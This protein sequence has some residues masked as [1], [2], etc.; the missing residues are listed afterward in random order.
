MKILVV[1]DDEDIAGLVAFNLERQGWKTHLVH[2]GTEAWE[3][4][5]TQLPDMVILDIMLPGMDGLSIFREMKGHAETS[6]IPTL[7]LTARAQLED[8]LEGLQLGADDFISKPF[9][10][11]ELVLRVKNVANRVNTGA[12]QLVIRSGGLVLDKNLLHATLNGEAL[13]LT[14]TEFR[15][16]SYLV[17]RPNKVQDR[18]D[19]QKILFDYA[20]TTQSRTLDT[21][22]KRLR[23]KLGEFA[24]CIATERGIG[25][26]YI[27]PKAE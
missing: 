20:D 2:D 1:E 23:Q 17:E 26:V 12:A 13:D 24:A 16:L 11:K 15:L 5:R 19:L 22:V 27:P 25:Y 3:Y 18:Y 7:F 6:H 21:H 14:T 8:R 10:P 4:I 9:S